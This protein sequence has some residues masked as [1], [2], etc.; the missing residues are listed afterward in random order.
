MSELRD[1]PNGHRQVEDG[2]ADEP[3]STD[4]GQFILILQIICAGLVSAVLIFAGFV[5]LQPA[6]APASEP[7]LSYVAAAFAA[8]MLVLSLVMPLV[9]D[10][11]AAS[12]VPRH[13]GNGGRPDVDAVAAGLM[14]QYQ[15]RKIVSMAVLEGAAFMN[16]AAYWL[17]RADWSLALIGGLVLLMLLNMPTHERVRT[18]AKSLI[19]R[20]EAKSFG[21]RGR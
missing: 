20:W 7:T 21:D 16:L 15:T 8:A 6:K 5:L 11:M 14:P 2:F 4:I 9:I 17:D 1:E 13:M 3:C 18:W 19:Q 10:R 12:R